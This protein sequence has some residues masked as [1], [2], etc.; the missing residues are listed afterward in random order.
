MSWL[1]QLFGSNPEVPSVKKRL[2]FCTKCEKSKE[3]TEMQP[4]SVMPLRLAGICWDCAKKDNPYLAHPEIAAIEVRVWNECRARESWNVY[5]SMF[6]E[7]HISEM[8]GTQ[9]ERFV[10]ELYARLGYQ[11][12]FT[13]AG[14]DQGVDLILSK[15]GQKIAVQAKQWKNPVGNAAVQAVI[16]GK[17]YY[18]CSR[19]IVITTSTFTKSARELATAEKTIDL[20][21]KKLLRSLCLQ[22]RVEKIPPFS[23][24]EWQKIKH[25]SQHFVKTTGVVPFSISSIPQNFVATAMNAT[26]LGRLLDAN[27]NRMS[28]EQLTSFA[29]TC[30]LLRHDPRGL[31]LALEKELARN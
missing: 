11:C 15:D 22:F 18:G 1:K 4:T 19:G 20:V 16:A 24:A 29:K 6:E 13:P 31:E 28:L 7:C 26:S 27:I 3:L 21:D 25:V 17:C 8:S 12:E 5:F 23:L 30:Q 14:A 2:Y 9:F 10:G